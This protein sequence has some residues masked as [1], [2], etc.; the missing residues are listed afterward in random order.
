V[1]KKREQRQQTVEEWRHIEQPRVYPG[2]IL[3]FLLFTHRGGKRGAGE[4]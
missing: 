4:I 3:L 2:F 1:R